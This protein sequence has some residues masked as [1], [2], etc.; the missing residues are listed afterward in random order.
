M[1][2][3]SRTSRWP[4]RRAARWRAPASQ[5]SSDGQAR[6][7]LAAGQAQGAR[8]RR[9]RRPAG[10]ARVAGAVPVRH[11]ARVVMEE[12]RLRR[13]RLGER[14]AG[15][16]DA[17][18]AGRGTAGADLRGVPAVRG[19]GRGQRAVALGE[20]GARRGVPC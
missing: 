20:G 11:A 3:A 10:D 12:H 1:A 13:G 5:T 17:P 9:R 8:E 7:G 4:R 16:G 14:A 18:C 19:E 6:Q 2:T 15:E